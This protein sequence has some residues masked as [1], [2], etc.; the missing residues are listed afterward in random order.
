MVMKPKLPPLLV[1]ADADAGRGIGHVMRCAALAHAWLKRGGEVTFLSCNLDAILSR[2][3]AAAGAQMIAIRSPHPAD[4]DLGDTLAVI[5][6]LCSST[7]LQPWLVLD[8]Y[9]FDPDYQ[10]AVRAAGCR[11][12]V[13]DDMAHLAY[14]DADIVLNHGVHAA[15]L[16]YSCA[17]GTWLLQGSRYALLRREFQRHG[18]RNIALV[19]RARKVLVTMGGSDPVNATATVVKALQQIDAPGLKTRL[20]V[21][22]VNR[23]VGNLHGLVAQSRWPIVVETARE[24]LAPLMRWADLAITAGGG[25]CAELAAMGVPMLTLVVADNQRPIAAAL[26]T[27]GVA[28]NLGWH[29]DVSPACIAAALTAL[30]NDWPR[31]TAMSGQ[32]RALFDGQGAD[33]VVNA[34]QKKS[35]LRAA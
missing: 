15:Q 19:G 16:V 7:G 33:R 1:R 28:V 10:R 29:T 24:R 18:R 30:A 9:H 5:A 12:L 32:G 20:L 13:V 17:P 35:F 4:A 25:T 34:M 14:Y 26:H 2:G 31:R 3:L 21:G 22:P 27:A 6:P 8:G 11:L 23:H